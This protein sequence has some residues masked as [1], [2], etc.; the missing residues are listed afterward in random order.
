MDGDRQGTPLPVVVV[1]PVGHE[2]PRA[3][4][5]LLMHALLHVARV[6]CV[7]PVSGAVMACMSAGALHGL[8][9]TCGWTGSQV[10]AVV[11]GR[12]VARGPLV[13]YG[14][15]HVVA[16]IA[17][18][19]AA[20]LH[21]WLPKSACAAM[22]TVTAGS[23]WLAWTSSADHVHTAA[24][25][26]LP[27]PCHIWAWARS[28]VDQ[29]D[30]APA[31]E[32]EDGDEMPMPPHLLRSVRALPTCHDLPLRRRE[33]LAGAHSRLLRRVAQ[34]CANCA[35]S[36]CAA[37]VAAQSLVDALGGVAPEPMDAGHSIGGDLCAFSYA[38]WRLWLDGVPATAE[39]GCAAAAVAVLRD[40]PV[41]SRASL[42]SHLVCVG[43]GWGPATRAAV[44]A[45]VEAAV[46]TAW[47][48]LHRSDRSAASAEARQPTPGVP[49]CGVTDA[50][51]AGAAA[52]AH[53][54]AAIKRLVSHRD[55]VA[56]RVAEPPSLTMSLASMTAP[57]AALDSDAFISHLERLGVHRATYAAELAARTDGSP[58]SVTRALF[59]DSLDAA[60]TAPFDPLHDRH[61]VAAVRLSAAAAVPVTHKLSAAHVATLR[62]TTP[63]TSPTPAVPS[64]TTI[65]KVRPPVPVAAPTVPRSGGGGVGDKLA[66]LGTRLKARAVGAGGG[67]LPAASRKATSDIPSADRT[68]T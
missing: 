39:E 12:V 2:W 65:A 37:T 56:A 67:L 9:A 32:G 46:S 45:A 43:P 29:W 16:A 44:T 3:T 68:G 40:A 60:D 5:N 17:C 52:F 54:T 61:L 57:V 42:A 30:T 11:D 25:D 35:V 59:E 31:E 6:H 53:A 55:L 63:A 51:V 23:S 58:H 22:P 10:V 66:A 20:R 8:V 49:S 21:A 34:K 38:C 24:A 28:L 64:A 15:V 41:D 14:R 50:A 62:D 27:L 19:L 4:R 48:R 1:E 33:P 18:I 36:G 47:P 26:A 7:V 13:P